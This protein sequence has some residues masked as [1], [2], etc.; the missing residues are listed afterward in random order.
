MDSSGNSYDPYSLAWRY[1]GLYNPCA[2][3]IDNDDDDDDANE[4]EADKSH[5]S[6]GSRDDRDCQVKL[7]WAAYVDHHYKGGKIVMHC[8]L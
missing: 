7:L 2:V 1:L 3:E 6:G 4:D 8:T 5:Q